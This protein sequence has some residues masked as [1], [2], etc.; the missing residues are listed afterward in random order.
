MALASGTLSYSTTKHIET[1]DAMKTEADIKLA[2]LHAGVC[3]S[4]PD[5]KLFEPAKGRKKV[6][7]YHKSCPKCDAEQTL[8]NN[9]HSYKIQKEVRES[10][11]AAYY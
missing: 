6:I 11:I 8:R 4:H 2:Y 3:P 5:T 7:M 1:H 10:K 9:E